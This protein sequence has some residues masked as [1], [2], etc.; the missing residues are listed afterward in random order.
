M[1]MTGLADVV[2]RWTSEAAIEDVVAVSEVEVK[3]DKAVSFDEIAGLLFAVDGPEE[4]PD[5][6]DDPEEPA[7]SPEMV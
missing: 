1:A 7:Y 5:D 3:E 2:M 4:V 6:V